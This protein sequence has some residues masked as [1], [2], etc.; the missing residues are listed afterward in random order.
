MSSF[1][2]RNCA[3]EVL[4]FTYPKLHEGKKWFVDFFALD[5]VSGEM[6]RKKYH[7]DNIPKI[8]ERR[9]KAAE[10]IAVTLKK[11]RDG[12]NP[13]VNTQESRGFTLL[14][15]VLSRYMEY[16]ERKSRKKTKHSYQSRVNI[17]NQYLSSCLLP[18]KYAY[19]FDG[20][21]VNDFLDWLYLDRGVSERTRNNY[22]GWCYSFSEFLVSRKYI[23]SNPVD[24]IPA[25]DEKKKLRKDLTPTM[26]K[27][28]RQHLKREDK[29][30]L[31]AC[32]MEYFTFI[33]PTELSYLKVGDISLKDKTIF[34]SEDFSKNKKSAKVALNDTL[35]KLMI[36]LGVPSAP[37]S[38]YLFGKNFKPSPDRCNADQYNRRWKKMREALGWSDEYQFYSLKDSG[39]RDL[40]NEQGV[41]V[42]RDQARHSDVS[43]TN[44]Y[45]Q[46]HSMLV[47]SEVKKFKGALEDEDPDKA[48]EIAAG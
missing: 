14:S 9:K 28:M 26:L 48:S 24:H 10:I 36:E 34:V 6:R 31:L 13:W 2:E 8:G 35:L 20:A 25:L 12:W 22:R 41:V 30:F 45:I 1:K 44:R 18:I 33:R 32:Y 38:Y 17:L 19:Q 29:H 37:S 46:E 40:A 42:A 47:H 27:Q 5:P 3:A 15:D 39:I 7:I 21:F 23:E 4:G 16:I 43:T 11:L